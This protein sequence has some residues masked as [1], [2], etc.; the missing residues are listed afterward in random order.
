M[1]KKKIK[2][3]TTAQKLKAIGTQVKEAR[4]KLDLSQGGV[5]EVS[6][7][8]VGKLENGQ[9]KNVSVDSLVKIANGLG[10]DLKIDLVPI[11]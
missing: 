11:N 8:T 1:Q 7:V 6:Y 10:M 4:T 9:L 3:E 2:F 5:A